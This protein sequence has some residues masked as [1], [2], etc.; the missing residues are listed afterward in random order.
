VLVAERPWGFDSLRPHLM[1]N[2]NYGLRFL[3]EVAAL[4]SLA[5][6]GF[7]DFGGV[8]QWLIGLGAPLVAAVVWGRFMSPKASHP[9]VDPVRLLIEL[10][11]FG[12]GVAALFAAD[13]TVLGVVFA[14]LV[15]VHLGLTFALGQRP[16]AG[17]A[18]APPS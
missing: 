13:A 16:E 14:V 6:W 15:V 2:A 4:V 12:A 11:V 18:A 8:G 10:A 9:V 17:V 1:G 7:H 3:L 5:Y